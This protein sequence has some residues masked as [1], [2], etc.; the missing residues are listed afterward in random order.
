MFQKNLKARYIAVLGCCLMMIPF[1]GAHSQPAKPYVSWPLSESDS[2]KLFGRQKIALNFLCSEAHLFKVGAHV[3]FGVYALKKGD[4]LDSTQTGVF[5]VVFNNLTKE[6]I[7][8]EHYPMKNGLVSFYLRLPKHLHPGSY[9]VAAYTDAQVGDSTFPCAKNILPIDFRPWKYAQVTGQYISPSLCDSDPEL[10][11][12]VAGG[13]AQT[14][15]VIK[16]RFKSGKEDYWDDGDSIVPGGTIHIL[17]G[18]YS[19]LSKAEVT[20]WIA[21]AG[22]KHRQKFRVFWPDILHSPYQFEEWCRRQKKKTIFYDQA[23]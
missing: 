8:H 12:Q 10:V 6:V 19:G 17:L 16:Y 1:L 23:Y 14:A 4:K 11:L 5:L 15:R 7:T 18:D 2:I 22:K 3:T 20:T 21:T 13:N 9:S